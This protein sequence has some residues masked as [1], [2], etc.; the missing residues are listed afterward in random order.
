[1]HCPN[2]GQKI[3]SDLKFCR[4]CGMKLNSVV[5]AVNEHLGGGGE[6]PAER[7]SER[8]M[9]ARLGRSLFYGVVVM[10]IGVAISVVGKENSTVKTIGVLTALLGVFLMMYA[11]I[12][13]MMRVGMIP[14]SSK[15]K[16]LP[17]QAPQ[18]ELKPGDDFE[19]ADIV[20]SVTEGTTK[21][22]DK[23]KTKVFK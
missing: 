21:D 16:E 3:T 18:L 14:R 11:V 22:L 7:P 4:A 10:F 9:V 6:L 12:S 17:E 20:A 19:A 23:N 15:K 2:C 13:P 1:M 8:V 5:R